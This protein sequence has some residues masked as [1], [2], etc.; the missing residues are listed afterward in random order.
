M[1]FR[2]PLSI[3]IDQNKLTGPNYN[4]WF[5]NFKIVMNSERIVYVLDKKPPKEALSNVSEIELAKLEKWYDHDLQAKSYMLSS[6]S[7]E[8]QKRFEEAVNA[9]DI[10]INQKEIYSV[11]TRSERH[12]TIKELMTTRL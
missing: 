6:M 7:N 8:L 11:Q 2:N 3:I 9:P 1:T 10:H 5:Q 12:V 4:D